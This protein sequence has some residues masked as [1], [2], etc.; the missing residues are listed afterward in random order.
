MFS[1]DLPSIAANGT[2]KSQIV[3]IIGANHLQDSDSI[4]CSGVGFAKDMQ[5]NNDENRKGLTSETR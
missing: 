4:L 3:N 5:R 2:H 1:P